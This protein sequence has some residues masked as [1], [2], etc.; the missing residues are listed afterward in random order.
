M[1][2]Y[3][4][5]TF[6]APQIV[7]GIKTQTIRADRRRHAR[8]GERLQLFTG[9]RTRHCRKIVPDPVCVTV[10]PVRISFDCGVIFA[11]NVDGQN[12]TDAEMEDFAR[13][14]G[15]APEHYNEPSGICGNTALEN[16]DTFWFD[17]HP[18]HFDFF[19]VLIKWSSQ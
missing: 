15:F 13:Q 7:E 6:F 2:A 8:P 16:M 19:G 1:V 11:I 3:S 10:S 12:L 5:K 17:N 18:G 4:F 14:D 9:M